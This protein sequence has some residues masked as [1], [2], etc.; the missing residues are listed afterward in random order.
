[1]DKQRAQAVQRMQDYI[2]A[3]LNE[4]ITLKQLASEA[5]YSPWHAAK[6]FKELT[7]DA[8]FDYVRRLRLSSAALR[9]RDGDERV[10]DIA[11]DF[12]FDS[13]EG[14]TRAFHRTFGLSPNK[15]RQDKPP[16]WLY[17]TYSAMERYYHKEHTGAD[18]PPISDALYT[19]LTDFP[20]RKLLLK[21]GTAATEYFAY[22][23]EVGCDVWGLLCSVKEAL[24]EPLGLWLP[25]VMRPQGTS[26]YVQGVEL[27]LTYDGVIPD[28]F[29][30]IEL[31]ACQMMI[32]QSEPYDELYAFAAIDAIAKA[33]SVFD[34]AVE[35]YRYIT[36]ELPHFQLQ[37]EGWRGYIEGWPVEKL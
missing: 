27:P 20:A 37:P 11:L 23:D 36:D 30:L 16:V 7:G 35:G 33:I 31:P 6:A 32:F 24:N 2:D 13:H 15:Y 14:F 12:Q 28:G 8:P 29:D 22:C 25:D 18:A 1:M 3:H 4:P 34:L 9:L 21:R 26:R 17:Q 5:G 19:Q 10:L